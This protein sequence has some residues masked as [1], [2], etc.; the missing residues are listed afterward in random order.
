MSCIYTAS[1]QW[2]R[3]HLYNTFVFTNCFL[4]IALCVREEDE[5]EEEE[6][7][8]DDDVDDMKEAVKPVK[9]PVKAPVRMPEKKPDVGS[10]SLKSPR[11]P[12]TMGEIKTKMKTLVGKGHSLP[13]N[14]KKFENLVKHTFRL[15]DKTVIKELWV[16]VQTLK[17]TK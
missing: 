3:A 11:R 9:T 6:E 13:R 7:E 15:G 16:W 5:E 1:L 14:E 8:D 17:Q 10:N 12:F 2:G 4:I